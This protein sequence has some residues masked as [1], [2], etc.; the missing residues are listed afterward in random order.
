MSRIV[1]IDMKL[2]PHKIV[3]FFFEFGLDQ[4]IPD[5]DVVLWVKSMFCSKCSLFMTYHVLRK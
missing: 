5:V 1:Q 4:L 2:P 3:I